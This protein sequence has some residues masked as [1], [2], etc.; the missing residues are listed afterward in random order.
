MLG[1]GAFFVAGLLPDADEPYTPANWNANTWVVCFVFETSILSV[2]LSEN[3][4][5]LRN[6]ALDLSQIALS[7]IRIFVLAAMFIVFWLPLAFGT[8]NPNTPEETERLL[9]ANGNRVSGTEYMT[10]R[11]RLKG[12]NAIRAGDA[13]NTNWTDYVIGFKKLFPFLW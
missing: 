6:F 7:I 5:L 9:P 13:Q 10:S 1:V 8:Y 3:N 11:E 2:I 12:V 4:A